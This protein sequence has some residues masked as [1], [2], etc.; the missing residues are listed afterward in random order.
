MS[1]LAGGQTK[2]Q[3]DVRFAR[4]AVAQR[5]TFSRRAR[6]SHRASSS[7]RVLFKVGMARKSKLSMV[8]M[9]RELRLPDAAFPWHV[10]RDPATPVQ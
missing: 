2:S 9:S 10:A 5:K 8:L 6:N 1:T 3:S 7:T 4:A